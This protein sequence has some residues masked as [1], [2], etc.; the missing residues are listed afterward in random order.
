[1]NKKVIPFYG[2]TENGLRCALACFRSVFAYLLDKEFTWDE[3]DAITGFKND[4]A[5]WTLPALLYMSKNGIDVHMIEPFDY[6]K[7]QKNGIRYLSQVF[8]PTELK[9]QMEN[10]NILEMEKDIP[11][12]LKNIKQECRNPTLAD[13]DGML[14]K[15]RI[16]S[17]VVNSRILN[18]KPGY[19]SHMILVYGKNGDNYIAHDPGL[20]P[21]P[22]RSIS[23]RHLWK[24]MG[25]GKAACDVTGYKLKEAAKHAT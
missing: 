21:R 19:V 6:A 23:A 14:A 17:V 9:W 11:E 8:N 3:L 20:P 1:M 4:T 12:F 25:E 10:S 5:A 15:G 24:A 18:D 7:F 2:N 16:V 13:I 22:E